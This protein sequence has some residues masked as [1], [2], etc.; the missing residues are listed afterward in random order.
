M[1]GI[2]LSQK[3]QDKHEVFHW[4]LKKV[5]CSFK[6]WNICN[7]VKKGSIQEDWIRCLKDKLSDDQDDLFF[8]V[9]IL[10]LWFF[11]TDDPLITKY[12]FLSC[13][14]LKTSYL[15]SVRCN[16]ASLTYTN[17]I[18]TIL[19]F[20]YYYLG[21]FKD[22]VTLSILPWMFSITHVLLLSHCLLPIWQYLFKKPLKMSFLWVYIRNSKCFR[23]PLSFIP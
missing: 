13:S 6:E 5:H 3:H 8:K 12:T 9:L 4:N 15:S 18:V 10:K 20:V 1:W 19:T 11:Y 16:R 2:T 17:V 7:A 22:K 21:G 14:S 23:M